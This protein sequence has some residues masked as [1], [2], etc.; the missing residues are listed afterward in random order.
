MITSEDLLITYRVIALL[1]SVP[2]LTPEEFQALPYI[3]QLSY[4]RDIIKAGEKYGP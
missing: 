3:K 1:R 2:G 4:L